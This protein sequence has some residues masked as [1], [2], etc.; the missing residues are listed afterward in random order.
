MWR[1]QASPASWVCSASLPAV[2]RVQWA[3]GWVVRSSGRRPRFRGAYLAVCPVRRR[4]RLVGRAPAEPRRSGERV[5]APVVPSEP[6]GRITGSFLPRVPR[7]CAQGRRSHR[8]PRRSSKWPVSGLEPSA[9]RA[10]MAC[11]HPRRGGTYGGGDEA[12]RARRVPC[13]CCC[14]PSVHPLT[15]VALIEQERSSGGGCSLRCPPF[16]VNGSDSALS[17]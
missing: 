2:E 1:S 15:L 17:W 16:A 7:S 14:S 5:G 3:G 10:L 8:S 11:A 9:W 6:G 4:A 13:R 12:L